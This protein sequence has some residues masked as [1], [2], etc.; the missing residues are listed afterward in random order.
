MRLALR[1][2][3]V[4]P[5]ATRFRPL[6]GIWSLGFVVLAACTGVTGEPGGSDDTGSGDDEPDVPDDCVPGPESSGDGVDNDCDGLVDERLVCATGDADFHTIGGAVAATPSGGAIEV[7]AGS[8]PE[9]IAITGKA[10]R[11][12]GAGAD[13]TIIDAGSAATAISITGGDEVTLD[14]FTIRGGRT[15]G[16]GGGVYCFA[17]GVRLRSSILLGNRAGAGGGGLYAE[18]CTVQI[19]ESHFEGNEGT[20]RGGGAAL[21]NSTGTVVD[22]VFIGN[23][24]DDGGALALLGGDIA[25]SA[26]ELRANLGRVHGGAIYQASDSLAE[27]NLITSNRSNWTGG[28]VYV[29]QHAPTFV[30]NT[31]SDNTAFHEG[32]GLYLHESRAALTDNRITGNTAEDD[33]GGLRMFSCDAMLERN[34]IAGNHAEGDGGGLKSSHVASLFIDN[35]LIDNTADGAGG[36]YELDNDSS[37]VIGGLVSGNSASIGGGI[38]AMLW[39]WNGGLLEGIRVVDNHATHGGG[40]YVEDNFQPMAIRA[41]TVTGNTANKGA[42]LYATGGRLVMSN[43]LFASNISEGPGGGLYFAKSEPWT[44]MCPCPPVDPASELDFV[45]IHGNTATNGSALWTDAPN[46]SIE[47]TIVSAHAGT[48]VAVGLGGPAPTW[49]YNDT[50]PV[51]FTGML[52]PT[53]RDGNQTMEPQFTDA[54]SGNF[55]LQPTSLCV[56]AGDPTLQDPDGTRA[57]MGLFAGPGAP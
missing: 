51:S 41:V 13:V 37:V 3:T 33:G 11:I 9:V 24:A 2:V 45:V 14:G 17:S 8:Y 56:D 30:G 23:S 25:V 36:G 32:G 4:T 21:I 34:H 47:N 12:R 46:L 31:I 57:D 20:Q 52:D 42:G 55:R 1:V 6:R 27:G 22:S 44:Q 53:G 40:I 35:E 48:A 43:S 29:K 54:A 15:L 10:L 5:L 49:R 28:G 16:A 18:S 39:P 7:C 19:T 26:S 50:H 38:H